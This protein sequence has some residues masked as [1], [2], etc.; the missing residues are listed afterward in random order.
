MKVNELAVLNNEIASIYMSEVA[1]QELV[2]VGVVT[3]NFDFSCL[4]EINVRSGQQKLIE[5][6]KKS[7]R[8]L[9]ICLGSTNL[10]MDSFKGLLDVSID[11]DHVYGTMVDTLNVTEDSLNKIMS[12][13]VSGNINDNNTLLVVARV[14]QT[15]GRYTQE[16]GID[17]FK[18]FVK[19]IEVLADEKLKG[20]RSA[21]KE[22]R[23]VKI[24]WDLKEASVKVNTDK[25]E[26]ECFFIKSVMSDTRDAAIE[27]VQEAA[28]ELSKKVQRMDK[29][30]AYVSQNNIAH[31]VA[32]HCINWMQQDFM[33]L[34]FAG[35]EYKKELQEMM[36][37]NLDKVARENARA[38]FDPYFMGQRNL[39]RQV[40]ATVNVQDEKAALLALK[41]ACDKQAKKDADADAL[42][43]KNG[44]AP[45]NHAEE[46]EM[47][48]S[49]VEKLLKEEYSL[50]TISSDHIAKQKLIMCD[51][52]VGEEVEF[53]NCYA[54]KDGKAAYAVGIPDGMYVITE[55]DGKYYATKSVKKH[56][57][58]ELESQKEI[59]DITIRI[60]NI[61]FPLKDI[62]RR[63]AECGIELKDFA[64]REY[65]KVENGKKVTVRQRVYDAI[66]IN[67]IVVGKFDCPLQEEWKKETKQL[68]RSPF[69]GKWTIK[70]GDTFVCSNGSTKSFLV[71]SK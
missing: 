64:I 10:T 38:K 39:L 53:N 32:E 11:S 58:Q 2:D 44:E 63:G 43:R 40:L 4:A 8:N 46:S 66:V 18:T 34:S 62:L 28:E 65:T 45:V 33:T 29:V 35:R 14:L 27:I 7:F 57:K 24:N 15:L 12:L 61:F 51:I 13:L 36:N 42:A 17:S 56:M 19:P 60:K 22:S 68:V 71:L 47:A 69:F 59:S 16:Y 25:D 55:E 67:N 26:E 21:L 52:E 50:L 23:E 9:G 3:N 1:R 49:L 54:V 5:E 41:V 70:M 20:M 37:G 31:P 6:T 30:R 48:S